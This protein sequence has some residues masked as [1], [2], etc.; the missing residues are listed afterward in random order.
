[1]EYQSFTLGNV[2]Q[3][4]QYPGTGSSG[5]MTWSR[6]QAGTDRHWEPWVN[7][8][9]SLLVPW[10]PE[11][12]IGNNGDLNT[13]TAFGNYI[14]LGDNGYQ[15]SVPLNGHNAILEVMHVNDAKSLIIQKLTISG[16]LATYI[17]EKNSDGSWSE[18]YSF[19]Q[20][21]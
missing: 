21:A 7:T 20:R 1:M 5:Y 16:E 6:I 3:E 15:N 9:N 13:I 14:L 8:N 11:G 19:G 2:I 10:Y 12:H 17:R 18:W 4:V